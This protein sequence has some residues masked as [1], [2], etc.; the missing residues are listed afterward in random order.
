[1][2]CAASSACRSRPPGTSRP[3]QGRA[4]GRGQRTGRLTRTG[5]GPHVQ[6]AAREGAPLG[7]RE[8]C[9]DG[10]VV[11]VRKPCGPICGAVRLPA[12]RRTI[13]RP[14]QAQANSAAVRSHVQP[15]QC[16]CACALQAVPHSRCP[17][18]QAGPALPPPFLASSLRVL[19]VTLGMPRLPLSV[20]HRSCAEPFA[21][22]VPA[23]PHV[24]HMSDSRTD[25]AG[26]CHVPVALVTHGAAPAP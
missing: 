22:C 9:R 20:V 12:T 23:T 19:L 15:S 11:G 24:R 7:E 1:M 3:G 13:S 18:P 5:A 6:R 21:A 16:C 2:P 4:R 10:D 17:A 8:G 25:A 26:G 14:T